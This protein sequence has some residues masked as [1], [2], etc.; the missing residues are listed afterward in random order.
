[1]NAAFKKR[2]DFLGAVAVTAASSRL[3]VTFRG[4]IGADHQTCPC[5][6]AGPL[7]FGAPGSP[8]AGTEVSPLFPAV[9][10][11]CLLLVPCRPEMV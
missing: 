9:P 8:G 10:P 7:P 3:S 2:Y 1:M 11:P 5:R 4:T 6:P